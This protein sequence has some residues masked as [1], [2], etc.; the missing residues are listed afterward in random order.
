MDQL[1]DVIRA[2][3][4]TDA[5]K[6]QKAAGAQA[7]RTIA[8]ALDTEPGKPIVLAG[9]PPRPPLAGVSLDQVLDLLIGRLTS[10]AN[11]HDANNKA[12]ELPQPRDSVALPAPSRTGLRV[13]T[14]A[15]SALPLPRAAGLARAPNGRPTTRPATAA[16]S[17]SAKKP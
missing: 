5:N 3:I 6:E 11:A 7:C 15:R 17:T 12:P 16:R 1:I 8:A 14:A 10:I 13:P 4:A 9:T 2:A